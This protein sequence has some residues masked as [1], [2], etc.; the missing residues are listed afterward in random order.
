LKGADRLF[1]FGHNGLIAFGLSHLDEI[2]RITQITFE[3]VDRAERVFKLGAFTHQLLRFFRI[4]P[5]IRAFN[6]RVE[7]G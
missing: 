1:R 7:F 6:K 4:V 2:F 5:E 3:P